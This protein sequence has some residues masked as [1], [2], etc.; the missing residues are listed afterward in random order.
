M[1]AKPNTS[2]LRLRPLGGRHLSQILEIWTFPDVRRHLWDD[3][4]IGEERVG[5]EIAR[6]KESFRA[7]GT[8]QWAVRRR[9]KRR[10]IG[11]CGLLQIPNSDQFELV[12]C[13]DPT[14]RNQGYATEA[15]QAVVDYAFLEAGL[16]LL[17]GRCAVDNIASVRVLEKVGMR[18]GRPHPSPECQGVHLSLL[19]DEFLAAR[20]ER[21]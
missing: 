16:E 3:K 10:V 8:G 11:S 5:L 14:L 2:R 9:E 19:R 1:S 18:P 20:Q 15:A 7:L 6:S 12:Y 13:I 21:T 17:F 4:I